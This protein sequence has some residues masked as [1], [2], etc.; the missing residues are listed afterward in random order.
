MYANLGEIK[1]KDRPIAARRNLIKSSSQLD[2]DADGEA[3][4]SE[5][6]TPKEKEDNNTTNNEDGSATSP[7]KKE[8]KSVEESATTKEGKKSSDEVVDTPAKEVSEV[9]AASSSSSTAEKME[10][11]EEST[12]SAKKPVALSPKSSSVKLPPPKTMEEIEREVAENT[13][14]FDRNMSYRSTSTK[15]TPER[16]AQLEQLAKRKTS[17]SV[18][19]SNLMRLVRFLVIGLLAAYTGYR[20][21]EVSRLEALQPSKLVE[22][23]TV[24]VLGLR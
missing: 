14:K 11:N 15:L 2:I 8:E 18:D 3:A 5:P 10:K 6:A 1:G 17:G 9:A 24:K 23:Q 7:V 16:V 13:A 19:P 22:I 20:T 12:D 21:A 4:P